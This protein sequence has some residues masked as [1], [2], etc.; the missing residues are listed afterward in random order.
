MAGFEPD[1]AK[2]TAHPG[3]VARIEAHAF[4]LIDEVDITAVMPPTCRKQGSALFFRP[5]PR[6]RQ[7]NP[8]RDRPVRLHADAD[9][10][11]A[12]LER[13]RQ[14]EI[15][16]GIVVEGAEGAIGVER[17]A[18]SGNVVLGRGDKIGA[19][20]RAAGACVKGAD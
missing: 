11:P 4:D 9:P 13:P 8:G 1:H 10:P 17:H 7:I 3:Q 15:G 14:R 20:F 18:V 5:G 19:P 16:M 2:R 12:R 6:T